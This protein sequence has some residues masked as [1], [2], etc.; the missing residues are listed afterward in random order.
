MN[1]SAL[2]PVIERYFQGMVEADEKLLREVF[3]PDAQLFGVF[4]GDPVVIPLDAWIDRVT[5]DPKPAPDARLS[6]PPADGVEWRIESAEVTGNI[7]RVKVIDRFLG[8]WY[9]DYLTL[10]HAEGAWRIVNKT[11]T[12]ERR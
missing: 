7:A 3:H 12:Y 6:P 9:T 5:G 11:F 2:E 4:G 10:L 1:P 8:V